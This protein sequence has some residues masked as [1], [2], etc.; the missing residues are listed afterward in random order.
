MAKRGTTADCEK[1]QEIILTGKKHV[2]EISKDTLILM[3]A[4]IGQVLK[5]FP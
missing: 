1:G 2:R 3:Q 5:A 4:Q